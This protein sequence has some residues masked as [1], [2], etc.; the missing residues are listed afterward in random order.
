MVSPAGFCDRD[1]AQRATRVKRLAPGVLRLPHWS[2]VSESIIEVDPALFGPNP[3][4]PS[5]ET[6]STSLQVHVLPAEAER[7]AHALASVVPRFSFVVEDGREL[8]EEEMERNHLLPRPLDSPGWV[9]D[10]YRHPDGPYV[11][12]DN[13]GYMAPEAGRTTAGIVVQALREA[14]V[15][16]ARLTPSPEH[17]GVNLDEV[18]IET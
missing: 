7:A 16:R 15:T 13:N 11:V 4:D 12:I 6:Q 8:D 5:G 1:S 17:D 9:S 14:G 10:V 2:V 3:R 18:W